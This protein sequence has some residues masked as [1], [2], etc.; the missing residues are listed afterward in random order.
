MG[1]YQLKAASLCLAA[2]AV[3]L[4]LAAQEGPAPA[5]LVAQALIEAREASPDIAIEELTCAENQRQIAISDGQTLR[6]PCGL[7][8]IVEDRFDASMLVTLL[9]VEPP[10]TI[11]TFTP[12]TPLPEA[13]AA[14]GAAVLGAVADPRSEIETL[15]RRNARAAGEPSPPLA[16]YLSPDSETFRQEADRVRRE[17]DKLKLSSRNDE[18][19]R[20]WARERREEEQARE[21]RY[22]SVTQFLEL[23]NAQSFCPADGRAFLMRATEYSTSPL[24]DDR[25]MGLWA[26]DRRHA[27]EPYLNDLT[28]CR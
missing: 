7:Q 6:F 24:Q 8:E 16:S 27:L 13:A 20:E 21:A 12:E 19:S 2:M 22:A 15:E 10:V 18:R 1:T 3:P 26:D 23:A 5:Q 9:L 28:R 17:E 4:P 25:P 11:P 14:L